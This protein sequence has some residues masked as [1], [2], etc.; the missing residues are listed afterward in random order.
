[1]SETAIDEM[2]QSFLFKNCVI[3][4]PLAQSLAAYAH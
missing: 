3:R 1:M 4:Q 2:M